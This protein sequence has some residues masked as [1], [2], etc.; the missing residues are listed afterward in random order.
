MKG[1]FHFKNQKTTKLSKVQ[2]IRAKYDQNTISI[3]Q[4]YNKKIADVAVK[5]QKFVAPF[6]F[7]RMTWIKPSFFMDDGKKSMGAKIES[8][9]NFRN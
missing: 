5:N 3:Y 2:E 7:N 6:S 8:R 9:S 4:A 1:F